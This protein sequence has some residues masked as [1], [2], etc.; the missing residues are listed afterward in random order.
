[1]THLHSC[2]RH[3]LHGHTRPR[4][5]ALSSLPG[6]LMLAL[7]LVLGACRK[8]ETESEPAAPV[9]LVTLQ[10][11]AKTAMQD[12]LTA[13]GTTEFDIARAATLSVQAESRV[14]AVLVT[15][16]SEVKAGQPLLRLVPT[17]TTTLELSA[18]HRDAAVAEQ[19]RARQ[20]RLRDEGLATDSELASAINAATT[21]KALS[22]SLDARTGGGVQTLTAPRA[23]I[24]DVL[25]AQPGDVLVPGA[26]ALRIASPDALQLRLGIEPEDLR[27]VAVGQTVRIA[28]LT[29]GAE[30]VMSRIVAIDRRIDSQTRLA[31]ALVQVPPGLSL[32]GAVL[33]GE[34]VI[35][36]HPAA[37]T[38]PRAALLF[39]G[40]QPLA[41]VGIDGKAKPRKLKL[42]LQ[43][44]AQVEVLDGIAVGE[45]VVVAGN[46]VLADD[47]AIRTQTADTAAESAPEASPAKP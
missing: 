39:D 16:G 33:R 35:A 18:A 6:A 34:I 19:E 20:Q 10:P 44:A 37:V 45:P 41:Y 46:S 25:G 8:A 14:V 36:T 21:T 38:I 43:D 15:L 28:P 27:R 32:P 40:E 4:R 9:A 42:G 24:V 17:P 7:P 22:A 12:L 31:A 11:A 26:S 1:M 5:F 29:P 13:Y 30:A 3:R 47:M 23:G 2:F